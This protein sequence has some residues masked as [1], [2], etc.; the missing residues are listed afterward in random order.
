MSVQRHEA[1]A[2]HQY[3]QLCPLYSSSLSPRRIT[4]AF[5]C[6]Y[7]QP[8]FNDTFKEWFVRAING[9]GVGI[10]IIHLQD[11]SIIMVLGLLRSSL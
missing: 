2:T 5:Q 8:N 1:D 10:T 6:T 7:E 9:T 4:L 11:C 3:Q